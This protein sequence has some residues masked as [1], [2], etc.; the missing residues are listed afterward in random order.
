MVSTLS[1]V[2]AEYLKASLVPEHF[3][4]AKP[5]SV[6]AVARDVTS[7]FREQTKPLQD[8]ELCPRNPYLSNLLLLT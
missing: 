1:F 5:T 3:Q 2:P 8:T 7:S 4:G 6:V